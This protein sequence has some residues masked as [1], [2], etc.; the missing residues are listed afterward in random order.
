L[1]TAFKSKQIVEVRELESDAFHVSARDDQDSHSSTLAGDAELGMAISPKPNRISFERVFRSLGMNTLIRDNLPLFLI[2]AAYILAIY[3][4]HATWGI[5]GRLIIKCYYESFASFSIVFSAIL[6]LIS[7]IKGSYRQYLNI[8]SLAG[9]LSVFILGPAFKSAFASYKQTIP[10]INDFAW[11]A[12][13]SRTDYVLHGGHHPW[14]LLQPILSHPGILRII[15]YAYML[16]FLFLFLFCLYM[17]WSRRRRLRLC[18]F[19]S[20]LF[21]WILLGSGLGTV[22]SSAGPCYYSRVNPSGENPFA[23]LM[24]RLEE[25]HRVKPLRAVSNQ[26]GLWQAKEDNIW[27]PFGG[28]IGHAKH[29]PGYGGNFCSRDI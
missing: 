17:A 1:N 15:D 25:I 3:A 24:T 26:I 7:L 19:I 6:L 27:L 20:T 2:F 23:P 14:M 21:V 22:F 12:F 5:H 29:S 11:D 9:F 13:L 10:L 4:T 18:F 8:N 16:W 28:G